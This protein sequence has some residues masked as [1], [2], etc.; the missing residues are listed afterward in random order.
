MLAGRTFRTIRLLAFVIVP[1]GAGSAGILPVAV[2]IVAQGVAH[3]EQDHRAE[4]QQ[5]RYD[6]IDKENGKL[7]LHAST[8]FK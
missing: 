2:L 1:S 6:D 5:H 3:S 4:G 7:S 8:S